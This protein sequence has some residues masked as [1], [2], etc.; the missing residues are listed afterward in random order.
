MPCMHTPGV[1]NT[2]AA[3]RVRAYFQNCACLAL[4]VGG[5]V[6]GNQENGKILTLRLNLTA[7]PL[8][9]RAGNLSKLEK[10]PVGLFVAGGVVGNW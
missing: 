4:Q 10:S 8:S 5:S 6:N 1:A 3:G 7:W 2:A 9:D